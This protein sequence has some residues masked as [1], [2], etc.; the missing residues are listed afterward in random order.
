MLVKQKGDKGWWILFL[1][2]VGVCLLLFPALCV[3]KI[4]TCVNTESTAQASEQASEQHANT[5]I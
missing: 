1:L 5:T 2:V 4:T 3:S